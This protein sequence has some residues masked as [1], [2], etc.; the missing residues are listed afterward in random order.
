MQNQKASQ[1][2]SSCYLIVFFFKCLNNCLVLGSC[3]NS[4]RVDKKNIVKCHL[5]LDSELII[6]IKMKRDGGFPVKGQHTET[7]GVKSLF[8]WQPS[9][10]QSSSSGRPPA[11]CGAQLR[12]W[13]P[14][15]LSPSQK[16]TW[17]STTRGILSGGEHPPPPVSPTLTCGRICFPEKIKPLQGCL[18][19]LSTHAQPVIVQPVCLSCPYPLLLHYRVWDFPL[20]LCQT[21]FPD[22]HS[23]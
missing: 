3:E 13:M 4:S 10:C 16:L 7:I 9:G 11:P 12:L 17:C 15:L 22:F 5:F 21:C 20:W 1:S 14:A 8:F 23:G 18:N 2:F 6:K 19:L